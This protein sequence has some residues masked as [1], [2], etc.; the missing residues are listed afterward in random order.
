MMYY[1]FRDEGKKIDKWIGTIYE[2]YV[3]V[4]ITLG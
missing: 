3:M 1:V 4:E 2:P